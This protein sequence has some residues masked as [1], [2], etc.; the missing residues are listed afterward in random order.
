MT[1]MQ[2]EE[3]GGLTAVTVPSSAG[4]A[5]RAPKFRAT[6][7]LREDGMANTDPT[8]GGGIGQSAGDLVKDLQKAQAELQKADAHGKGN[9]SA[10]LEAQ[11][12]QSLQGQN[13]A[14]AGQKAGQAAQGLRVVDNTTL[15]RLARREQL[16]VNVGTKVG[17]F[18][19][20]QESQLSRMIEN[21]VHGQDKMTKIMNIALSGRQFSPSELLAMQAGVYRFSQELDLTSKVVEKAT[22][23]IK[24]TLNTQV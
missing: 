12:A 22:G 18:E 4:Y 6:F 23:G 15:D 9:F 8:G 3:G 7:F 5:A 20:K 24:Q 19:K 11:N 21:L 13:Q 1:G 16:K 14:L 10:A 2:P 17:A